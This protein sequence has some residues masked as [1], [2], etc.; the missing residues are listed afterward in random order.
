MFSYVPNAVA[1]GDAHHSSSEIILPDNDIFSLSVAL[2]LL[3]FLQFVRTKVSV[4]VVNLLR[5]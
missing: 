5:V 3:L 2:L 4:S 1:F